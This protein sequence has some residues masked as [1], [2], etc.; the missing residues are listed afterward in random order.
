MVSGQAQIIDYKTGIT[1]TKKEVS[2][3]YAPQL[4]LEGIILSAGGF[5]DLPQKQVEKLSYWK[6]TGGTPA[7]KIISFENP[8]DLLTTAERGVRKLFEVFLGQETP[9]Y[10]CPNPLVELKYND[11]AHLERLKEWR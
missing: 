6:M 5:T 8:E 9:F 1:P 11:Y 10:A 2:Q 4:P 3:G 7:A